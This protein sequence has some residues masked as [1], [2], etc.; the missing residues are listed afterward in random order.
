[1]TVKLWDPANNWTLIA[2]YPGHT[3]DI[4]DLAY[5]N[6]TL[7]ASSTRGQIHIWSTVTLFAVK[8]ISV[9]SDG[10]C[11]LYNGY[12]AGG[13]INDLSIW[14]INTGN[15]ISTLVGHTLLP[16]DIKS[17]GALVLAS[18]GDDQTVIIWD[19]ATYTK[20]YT[21][22]GH[23]NSVEGLVFVTS[24][25]L[26]SASSD[27]TIK[28]WDVMN[29]VLVRTLTGHTNAIQYAIDVLNNSILISGSTDQTV[30]VWDVDTGATLITLN[31]G[32]AVE[33]LSVLQN[34]QSNFI[35]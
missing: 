11:L 23:T 16:S 2:T 20:N 13:N 34:Y 27:N 25:I 5:V 1:M 10:L 12:L 29:G 28:I 15:V 22:T 7:M 19:L 35:F 32:T 24:N 26:A 30:K 3:S 9:S 14:D 21:L 31:I 6:S 17:N 18:S 33:S 8:I 4:W